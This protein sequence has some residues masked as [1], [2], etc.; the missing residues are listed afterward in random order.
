MNVT[1][2]SIDIAAPAATIY[3][4]ASATARWPLIL[5]HYRYVRVHARDGARQTVEMAAWRDVFPLHWVAEQ[6]NDAQRPH[7]AFRHIAGPTRG[8]E[9]EWTFVPAGEDTRVTIEHRLEFA[10]PVLSEWLGK[11]VVGEYFIAGVAARTLGCIK[12]L[13]EAAARKR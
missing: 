9:V 12:R 8:M 10:F 13:A 5:P 3:A 1:S 7:I 2:T 4:L 11:Y 6:T